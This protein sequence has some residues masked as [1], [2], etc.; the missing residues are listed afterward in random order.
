M[1]KL[2]CLFLFTGSAL[3]CLCQRSVLKYPFEFA[4]GAFQMK[5]Y[6]S[7]Y[8]NDPVSQNSMLVLKD[9]KKVE[10]LLLDK[11]MKLVS[12]FS[13]AD[14]LS[15]T[16]FDKLTTR[17]QAEYIGG[18]AG[19]GKF[20]F[21]YA[22]IE[23]TKPAGI[24]L[25]TVDPV[26]KTV[27]NKELFDIPKDEKG[28]AIFGGYG[29]F[30]G[31]TANND[32]GEIVLYKLNSSGKTSTKAIKVN[33][34]AS[35]KRKKLSDYLGQPKV[36]TADEEPGLE[37]AT[38]KEKLFYSPNN[39]SIVVNNSDDPTH[40]LKINTETFASEEKFV[41][42][43]ALTK[44][45]KGKS[46]VNSYSFGDNLYSLVLNK[47]NIRI[48]I[49]NSS[50]GDLLKIHEINENTNMATFAQMPIVEERRGKRTDEKSI[51]DPKKLIRSLDKGSEAI[52]MYMD[53]KNRLV[54]SIGTYD[55][56]PISTGGSSPSYQNVPSTYALNSSST[57]AGALYNT[58][59]YTPGKPSYTTYNANYYKSTNFKLLLDP[60]TLNL[61]KG[62]APNSVVDQIKD[63]MSTI[64]KKAE[65]KN[66]FSVND[67][68]YFGYYDKEMK[69]YF[70][71]EIIIR[72]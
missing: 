29:I 22:I 56:I 9:N 26:G 28:I 6:D 3:V 13:P 62:A 58:T 39:I 44:D 57:R 15:N 23:G 66:Q 59:Y 65:A 38:E 60:T 31:I 51:D 61:V 36:F 1:Y 50:T 10:Y 69:T 37:S 8:L 35:S 17:I 33:I 55:M 71:E 40:I 53:K 14:G 64:S 63:Y 2:F 19:D 49:Y 47:K 4:K 48:A 45:E 24:F 72:K 27:S 43:S 68:E 5:D 16:I 67:K 32:D 41:D 54:I 21:A 42:H 25:E 30:F 20:Y 12:K 18:T 52:M 34:P 11:D 46:Y 70:I 7:Y